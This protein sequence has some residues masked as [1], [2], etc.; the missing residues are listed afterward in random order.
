MLYPGALLLVLLIPVS[1]Y[2]LQNKQSWRES[3]AS[4]IGLL[5]PLLYTFS[6]YFIF[7][8]ISNFI[9]LFTN[10]IIKR[11]D[12]ILNLLPVQIYFVYL[13]LITIF[14]SLFIVRQYDEKKIST[15]R[16]FKIFFFY[17]SASLLL[18]IL[19]SVSYE[20]LV[21][22]SIPLTFLFTN[23]LTFIRRKF[24]A[25]LFF[26]ILIVISLALQFIIK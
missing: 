15:R 23:Y 8:N 10:V 25:E 17:F 18:F 14:S 12:T 26:T 2:I 5:L 19:P 13:L 16:Y 7:N 9:D 24:W 21:I 3:F 20:L 11:E 1:F 22:L 6:Y 4:F